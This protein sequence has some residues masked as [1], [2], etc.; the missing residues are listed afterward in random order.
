[1]IAFNE[2]ML[3]LVFD[4]LVPLFGAAVVYLLWGAACYIAAPSRTAFQYSWAECID[5]LNWLYG[6]AILSV[7]AGIT[8]GHAKSAMIIQVFCFAAAAASL[9]LVLAAMTNRGQKP[10]WKPSVLMHV[11]SGVLVI[12]TLAAGYKAHTLV[13]V[14]GPPC[15]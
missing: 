10:A 11:V 9:M 6:S 1:L 15:K 4:A 12:V 14:G 7:Q 5:P 13:L 3:W 2:Q 8:S